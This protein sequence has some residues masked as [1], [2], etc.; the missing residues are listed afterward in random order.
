MTRFWTMR[1]Y[2]SLPAGPR[3][4]LL[5]PRARL[6]MHL[7]LASLLSALTTEKLKKPHE[8]RKETS[9]KSK[10]KRRENPEKKKEK[11]NPDPGWHDG[12]IEPLDLL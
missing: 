1:R 7:V 12:A 6:S 3:A 5:L 11:K 10:A 8:N 2:R 9:L 4:E